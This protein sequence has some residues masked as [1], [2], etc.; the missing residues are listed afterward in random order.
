MTRAPL[1]LSTI[2]SND[3]YGHYD[4]DGGDNDAVRDNA[5]N[6]DTK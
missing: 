1:F 5:N 2:D 4:Y 3:D 6:D